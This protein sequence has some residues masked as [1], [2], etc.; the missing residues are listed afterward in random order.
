MD[1][2]DAA[3]FVV[4]TQYVRIDQCLSKTDHFRSVTS[5]SLISASVPRI[6]RLLG[7]GGSGIVYPEIQETELSDAHA[8]LSRQETDSTGP[9]LVPPDTGYST[10]TVSAEGAREEKKKPCRCRLTDWQTRTMGVSTDE[11]ASTSSLVDPD[12]QDGVM[13]QCDVIVSV[14]DKD[15]QKTVFGREHR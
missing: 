5:L 8:S 13:M 1:A 7:V 3:E 2:D 6:K 12:K 14:E 15:S 4:F 9:K 11:D 10:V